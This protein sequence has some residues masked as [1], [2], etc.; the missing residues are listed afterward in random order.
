MFNFSSLLSGIIIG[1]I[2]WW[3]FAPSKIETIVER[4]EIEVPIIETKTIIKEIEI[5]TIIEKIVIKKVEVPKYIE[6]PVIQK[7]NTTRVIYRALPDVNSLK[8]LVKQEEVNCLALNIYREANNQ[9]VVG[10]IAVGRVVMNRVMDRRYPPDT[11]SVIF[12]GPLVESWKTRRNTKLADKDRIY[13][14][15]RDRCQFSW[16]CDGKRDELINKENNRAWKT[17]EDI[18]YQILAF[19]KWRGVLEGATHYHANYV[20]PSLSHKLKHIATIDDHIFY[21]RG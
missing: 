6:K 12:E 8:E 14:P 11:C 16:Y 18:A 15:K 20:S 21:K 19:D 1:A 3:G 2:G 7:I 17:A 5:P 10:M 13:Y 9:S 4:V